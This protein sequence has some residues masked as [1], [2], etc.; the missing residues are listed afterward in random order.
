MQPF[1]RA[2]A[3]VLGL[4][5]GLGCGN[6][7]PVA[8]L[9]GT[10]GPVRVA[11]DVVATPAARAQGLMYRTALGDDE[12]MLF[13]F[14]ET[15]DHGFWMKNTFIPLDMLFLDDALVVV[16]IHEHATPQ[17]TETISIGRPSRYVLEVPG[18]WAARHGVGAGTRVELSGV[19]G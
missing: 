11:L 5:L 9:H 7:R 16:G 3:L 12:G 6:D 13:V 4:A 18:G 2:T 8:T 1:A 10:H 19:P 17:S 14:D 15:S